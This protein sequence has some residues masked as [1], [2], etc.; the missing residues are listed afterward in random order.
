MNENMDM[1]KGFL[2][3]MGNVSTDIA[4]VRMLVDGNLPERG[5]A[6]YP[7]HNND[8]WQDLKKA[9]GVDL[10][11]P[12]LE[13][14]IENDTV[15]YYKT[16][17]PLLFAVLRHNKQGELNDRAFVKFDEKEWQ[18]LQEQERVG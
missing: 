5:Y 16:N 11:E 8:A 6:D 18:R 7:I 15:Q 17:Q 10:K 14:M 1:Y 13:F 12:A 2:G 3:S 4:Q 9:Y